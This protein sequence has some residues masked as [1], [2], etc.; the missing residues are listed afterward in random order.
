[1]IPAIAPIGH[2][3]GGRAAPVDDAW[4]GVEAEIVLDPAMLG[5]EATLGLDAFSHV[6]V[7]FVFDRIDPAGVE[8]GARHPR[9]R[10][11]WPRVGI[12]AQRG[13]PRPNRLGVTT[14]RLL[15]VAGMVL[16]V[17]GLDAVDGTPVLDV[18]PHMTGFDPRGEVRE[19]AWAREIMRGYW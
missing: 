15:G 14:C 17:R 1:M 18:K 8:R 4:D 7:V 16:R 10:R 5:A 13:S 3:R 6:T 11:D 12:L 19:P 9:G 2:V